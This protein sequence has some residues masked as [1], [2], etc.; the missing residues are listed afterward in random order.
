VVPVVRRDSK[1]R[2][3]LIK[4][5]A[6][7]GSFLLSALV[8]LK[9]GQKQAGALRR[10]AARRKGKTW[11][12]NSFLSPDA[13]VGEG[14]SAQQR[15]VPTYQVGSDTAAHWLPVKHL[16]FQILPATRMSPSTGLTI[17]FYSRS[18]R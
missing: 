12:T 10:V 11:Q 8:G 13:V 6:L 1:I 7:V 9:R 3:E 18:K 15:D 4:E 17:Q 14:D 2:F 16:K 5:P